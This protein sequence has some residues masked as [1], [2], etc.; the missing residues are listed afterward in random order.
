VEGLAN[1]YRR[2][3]TL[4]PTGGEPVFLRPTKSLFHWPLGVAFVLSLSIA[5]GPALAGIGYFG[6]VR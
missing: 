5:A 3:D 4:E 2:I 6:L 1:V